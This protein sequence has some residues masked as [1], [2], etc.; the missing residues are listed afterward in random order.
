MRYLKEWLSM[1]LFYFLVAFLCAS[2]VFAQQRMITGNVIDSNGESIIGATVKV[3][4][5]S[6]GTITDMTGRF[7]IELPANSDVI[8]VS[9]IGYLTQEVKVGNRNSFIITL[10]EDVKTL[11]EVVVVGYGTQKKGNVLASISTIDSDDLSRTTSS[12]TAAALVGKI[13]GVTS[14]QTSGTPGASAKLQIRNLG[15]P[16]YVI[17][18]IVKDEGSFNQLDVN[19]IDNISIL[20]DGAAAIYGVKAA[21]GVVL[22]T[23]KRGQKGKPSI[24]FN[25]YH[26]W[27]SWTRFPEMSN[28]AEYVLQT[29]SVKLM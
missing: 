25:Y 20:K 26:G 4:G 23:T 24:G 10:R 2:S 27:Q 29:T 3:K 6:A 28:A 22:V 21:N 9:Y 7:S 8:V 13:A 15:T 1:K 5:S 19:D 17:D 18:G 11:D 12:T 14:R 16:L